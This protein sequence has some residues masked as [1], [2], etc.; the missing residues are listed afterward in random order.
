MDEASLEL[1]IKKL[2]SRKDTKTDDFLNKI[3]SFLKLPVNATPDE[4]RAAWSNQLSSAITGTSSVLWH[5]LNPFVQILLQKKVDDLLSSYMVTIEQVQ[6][7]DIILANKYKVCFDTWIDS[8]YV[9]FNT[10]NVDALGKLSMKDYFIFQ[11]FILATNKRVRGD[12]CLQLGI[13][14]KSSVGKSTLFES[15]ISEISHYYVGHSGTGRFRTEGKAILFLHDID[16]RSL[17]VSK[18]RDLIKTLSRSEAT[19]TKVHS[20]TNVIN[21]IHVFYTSNTKIFNHKITKMSSFGPLSDLPTSKKLQCHV[22]AI[23]WRFLECFCY[24][25]PI[26]SLDWLPNCGMFQKQHMIMGLFDRIVQTLMDLNGSDCFFNRTQI[27][28]LLA[29]LAKN[30]KHYEEM[31]QIPIKHVIP[32]LMDKFSS[33]LA[34]RVD[35][36]KHLNA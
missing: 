25:R 10:H 34:E 33:P 18:D 12:N 23:R 24:E 3:I 21:P 8:P 17:V 28:Y 32:I 2:L 1:S 27:H 19:G 26:I 7:P 30:A 20:S 14:G 4:I 22:T 16:V 6:E 36:L 5:R 31:F 29:G 35:I 11:F 15:P 9:T 13:V